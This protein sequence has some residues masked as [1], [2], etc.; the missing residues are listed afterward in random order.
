M[1]GRAKMVWKVRQCVP[2]AR[3]QGEIPHS[4][5]RPPIQASTVFYRV[6]FPPRSP[7]IGG[8]AVY[9]AGELALRI[10]RV[11]LTNINIVAIMRL[12]FH[13]FQT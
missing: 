8:W 6:Q 9:R 3:A 7:F 13:R 11:K 12:K 1:V 10:D 4:S 2:S 5:S